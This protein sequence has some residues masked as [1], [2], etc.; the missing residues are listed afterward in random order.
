MDVA[1]NQH[2]RRNRSTTS[3]NH[4]SLAPLTSKLPLD[5][6][7]F[8]PQ[9]VP[10][11]STS[12]IAHASAPT[13]PGILSRSGSRA[14]LRKSHPINLAT[15]KST[16]NIRGQK[17]GA[18]TPGNVT[19]GGRGTR[20][21]DLNI[22]SLSANDRNN[23]DWLLRAGAMISSE[24]RESKGQSWL[25]SRASSTSLTATRDEAE[26]AAE[27]EMERELARSRRG[28]GA[29][30]GD[31]DDEFSP[32]TTR[33]CI[34]LGRAGSRASSRYGSRAHSRRNSRVGIG[35][36]TPKIV[37]GEITGYF[38]GHEHFRGD[39]IEPDF[40][41]VEDE[42]IE[43]EEPDMD[44]ALVRRLARRNSFGLQG[45][46]EKMLGW[47]LFAVGEEDEQED[48]ED[49]DID[50][51]AVESESSVHSQRSQRQNFNAK[52]AVVDGQKIPAPKA[53]EGG[54]QDAAWL[55]SVATKVLL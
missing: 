3:L 33:S 26:E 9:P 14:H 10:S 44:E 28:S 36:F 16:T 7:D 49:E 41:N 1:Y 18:G 2:S 15:S 32:I 34:N 51:V 25:V 48:D 4:L 5:D 19:P 47:K 20:R 50:E 46:V 27:R 42:T 17:L 29:G 21:E 31:A 55:L 12:Y 52:E 23:S 38:D 30:V 35:A 24:T 54:W 45:W 39:M 43:E 6:L 40:V 37:E 8:P 11:H 22:S 53:E 13:T